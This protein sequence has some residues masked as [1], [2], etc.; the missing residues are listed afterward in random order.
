MGSNF[1]IVEH[2]WRKPNDI[3]GFHMIPLSMFT[4]TPTSTALAPVNSRGA[5][6][7]GFPPL[8]Q[9]VGEGPA[10]TGA[11]ALAPCE[12]DLSTSQSVWV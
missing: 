12:G 7:V 1:R 8:F 6:E 3:S 10:H 5:L 4:Y 9:D 11:L 2:V